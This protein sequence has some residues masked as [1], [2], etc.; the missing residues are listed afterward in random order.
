[1][2]RFSLFLSIALFTFIG[3]AKEPIETSSQEV[4][5]EE[6]N[7][8]IPESS[9]CSPNLFCAPPAT[10]DT[11]CVQMQ[12]KIDGVPYKPVANYT[13][14]VPNFI[15]GYNQLWINGSLIFANK[16]V[17]LRMPPN[18]QPGEYEI[19]PNTDFD[20]F[21]V[22]TIDADNFIAT[23]GTIRIIEHDTIE[24]YILGGFDFFAENLDS[25]VLPVREF[26]KGCFEAYY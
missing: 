25:P 14:I 24:N 15:L 16:V 5:E 10:V 13:C 19:S 7:N 21:Y 8:E 12:M 2:K 22:P 4:V 17:T 23:S 18:V 9:V 3:C 1:M 26:T 11:S 6:E 20:A